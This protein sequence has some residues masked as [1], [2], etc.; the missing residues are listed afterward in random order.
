MCSVHPYRGVPIDD[1][2]HGLPRSTGWI[3]TVI[4]VTVILYGSN[5]MINI[6]IEM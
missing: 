6:C 5:N 2:V 1:Y 4:S 3:E